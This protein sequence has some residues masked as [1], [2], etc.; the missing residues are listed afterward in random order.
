MQT[1]MHQWV[2]GHSGEQCEPKLR[3]LDGNAAFRNEGASAAE[4][5]TGGTGNCTVLNQI[6][7][8]GIH[9]R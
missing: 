9:G 3:N 2:G 7:K 8:G 6:V 1:P 4:S 5:L